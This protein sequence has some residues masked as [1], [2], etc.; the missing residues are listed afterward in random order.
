MRP[1]VNFELFPFTLGK[2]NLP[3]K[4]PREILPALFTINYEDILRLI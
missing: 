3:K 2:E 4:E 1:Y